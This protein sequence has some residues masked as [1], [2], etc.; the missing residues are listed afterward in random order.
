MGLKMT[1]AAM[2]TNASCSP[3]SVLKH[4]KV[5]SDGIIDETFVL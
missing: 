3:I 4:E 1:Q 5:K 2:V